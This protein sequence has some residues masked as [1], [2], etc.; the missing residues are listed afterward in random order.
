MTRMI[1]VP[2]LCNSGARHW[3]S[4]WQQQL[5]DATRITLP[6]W[7]QPDLHSWVDGIVAAVG[8]HTDNYLVAHSF[9]CLASVAALEELGDRV[10]G[11]LLVA[12]AD[13]DKF[14][15]ADLLPQ[16]TLPVPGLVIGSL[17]DPWLSWNKAQLWA[18]RWEL[19]IYCAGDAGHINVESGHEEWHEGWQLL[20][21]L[22]QPEAIELAPILSPRRQPLRALAY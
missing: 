2:G 14:K 9:G 13:P 11:V 8:H 4:R 15:L 10:R 17:S 20:E 19:P 5:Q 12:P 18:Q 21:K 3:Q 1:I 16:S 22:Q 6:Q 7:E